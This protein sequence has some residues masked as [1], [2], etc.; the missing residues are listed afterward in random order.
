MDNKNISRPTSSPPSDKNIQKVAIAINCFK[1]LC[2]DS[3]KIFQALLLKAGKEDKQVLRRIKSPDRV[4]R[5]AL[6]SMELFI[7]SVEDTVR[8]KSPSMQDDDS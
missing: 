8:T 2:T 1:Q 5:K 7:D 6:D 4:L 3:E